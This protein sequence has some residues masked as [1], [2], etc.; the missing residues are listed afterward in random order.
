M[1]LYN[2]LLE[3]APT[4]EALH[5]RKARRAERRP[6]AAV[7]PCLCAGSGPEC[8]ATHRGAQVALLRGRGDARGAVGALTEFLA[9]FQADVEGWLELSD[10]YISLQQYRQAAFCLEELL[11]AMP[12]N[13]L[14]HC[15]YGEVQYTLGG[16]EGLR[17]ARKY[18]AAAVELTEGCSVRAL[19]GLALSAAAVKRLEKARATAEPGDAEAL[20]GLAVSRIEQLYTARG[21]SGSLPLVHA[22]LEAATPKK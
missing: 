6:A 8:R 16:E 20:G 14:V 9:I 3:K 21:F 5:K 19:Y 2:E 11:A 10:L 4:N 18:F 7:A 17:N 13:S 12:S 1:Q 22:G 15:K